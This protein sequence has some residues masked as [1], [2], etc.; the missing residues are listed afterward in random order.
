MKKLRILVLVREGLVP[1]ETL[2]GYSQEEIDEWK[3]EFDVVGTLREMGHE[4]RAI[5]VYDDL[6]P[7]RQTIRKW[8]PHI[9]FMLLE[10]F[11]GVAMYDYAIVS[12][13]ELM[14]QHYTGCNPI[15][16]LLSRDKALAKR[17]LAHHRISTPQ[18]AIFPI[19]SR[20]RRP[21]K[22]TFP[23]LVKSAAEDASWGIAQA[24]IV[25]DDAE[26]AERVKFVHESRH[27]DALV[28]QF[29]E[30]RELY[31]GVVGNVRLQSFPVWEMTFGN[32]PDD[33]HI[34][35]AK[36]KF[37]AR[38]QKK[39]GIETGPAKDLSPQLQVSIDKLC[40]RVY[41][42]LNMTGYARMDLRLR[43]DGSVFVLE[44]NAN[45]NLAYGEDFAES[46]ETAGVSYEALLQR[47]LQLGLRYHA[48]WKQ[49]LV[50]PADNKAD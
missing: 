15:G 36:V 37:D 34:A 35:T 30:G 50:Q 33:A 27:S 38:Y 24:S 47:I 18:F 13:L 20:V 22:L 2:E 21:K 28:E 43:P 14:R 44:A 17:I 40:K 1:P 25:W 10:E 11:H 6:G 29:I 9:H 49:S 4:V 41:R 8:S 32:M 12:Y 31:V 39:H 23:L 42:A 16:M 48:P 45:P 3:V 46:A 19:R 26:L 7:I 5:G